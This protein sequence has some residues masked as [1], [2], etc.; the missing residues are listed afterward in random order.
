VLVQGVP[1]G[2]PEKEHGEGSVMSTAFE[3]AEAELS[4][5]KHRERVNKMKSTLQA[6]WDAEAALKTAQEKRDG[7]YRAIE[8]FKKQGA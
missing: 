8:A 1:D 3:Q 5:E 7:L 6:F 4:E 2:A